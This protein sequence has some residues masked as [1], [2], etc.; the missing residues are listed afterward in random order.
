M[1]RASSSGR[2][3]LRVV[4]ILIAI[5]VVYLG[6]A[7]LWAYMVTPR[8]VM[9]ASTPRLLD[10][11][12]LPAPTVGILLRVEDPSFR[13]HH[14]IDPFAPGQGRVTISRALVHM[15]YLD[16]YDLT[17][18]A[19]GLQ[20]MYKLV[21]RIAGPVDLGPD[22]MALVVDA[23]LGKNRQL[24][25]F[26]QHV[27]MGRHGNRQ[28]YGLPDAARAYFGKDPRQLSRRETV[29]LVAM[30]IGPNQFHPVRRPAALAERVRR[31][32]RLLQGG[33][34]PRGLRD[35]HYR[36]CAAGAR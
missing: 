16:R 7:A 6:V 34:K 3:V 18:V 25:L 33:C 11:G 22:A 9:Q 30:M 21:D 32:E 4:V 8:V 14:G 12:S 2:R 23:R 15:L 26:L 17:G 19:G 29:T 31:I 28:I 27:Y 24:Q 35:V 20:S 5:L 10:L 1:A 13:T 36:G